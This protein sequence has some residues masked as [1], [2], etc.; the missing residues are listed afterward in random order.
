[1]PNAAVWVFKR[2][3]I[4][5]NWRSMYALG[6]LGTQ[7]M[8]LLY[9]TK[10]T[11][12]TLAVFDDDTLAPLLST[13]YTS[14]CSIIVT[15][16]DT[17]DEG[18]VPCSGSLCDLSRSAQRRLFLVKDYDADAEE[19]TVIDTFVSQAQARGKAIAQFR[20]QRNDFD[21]SDDRF[22]LNP[23][24]LRTSDG[25]S[26]CSILPQARKDGDEVDAGDAASAL[27]LSAALGLIVVV[28]AL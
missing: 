14:F 19:Q 8:A 27:S 16:K 6:V 11:N 25:E 3:L 21:Y 18:A 2:F 17:G 22:S 4:N 13:S 5:A 23:T 1:M 26:W 7:G 20:T 9:E 24:P 12:Y 10:K 28:A 15:Q